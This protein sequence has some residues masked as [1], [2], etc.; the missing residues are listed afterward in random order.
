MKRKLS[1][2]SFRLKNFKAVQDSKTIEFTPLTGFIGN[3][4]SGKIS[5]VELSESQ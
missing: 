4:S 3:N 1:L 2:A 5:I